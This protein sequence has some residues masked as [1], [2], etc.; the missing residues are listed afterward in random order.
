MTTLLFAHFVLV[1]RLRGTESRSWWDRYPQSALLSSL[2]WG[3]R[4]SALSGLVSLPFFASPGVGRSGGI[5]A[6]ERFTL[7]VL[8]DFL[9]WSSGMT[10]LLSPSYEHFALRY[11]LPSL[12]MEGL[13]GAPLLLGSSGMTTLL[14]CGA[15]RVL[16]K[17][18]RPGLVDSYEIY[19]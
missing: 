9:S 19:V 12:C 6:A 3:Y 11:L 4:E 5:P 14:S 1:C 7:D 2:D 17:K 18:S 16:I 8:S 10:T 13:G 15:L